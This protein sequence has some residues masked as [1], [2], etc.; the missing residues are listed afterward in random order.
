MMTGQNQRIVMLVL[1][2]LLVAQGCRQQHEQTKRSDIL[3][4]VGA[5]V[6]EELVYIDEES[7]AYYYSDKHGLPRKPFPLPFSYSKV[8]FDL[9]TII[10]GEK[11]ETV[12]VFFHQEFPLNIEMGLQYLFKAK[13]GDFVLLNKEKC[14]YPDSFYIT[15]TG[16]FRQIQYVKGFQI[17]SPEGYDSIKQLP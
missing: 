8:T 7:R 5:A 17:E 4:A 16:Y 12:E 11:S 3:V 10:E 1:L 15:R 14:L 2:A 9:D 6:K 13:R